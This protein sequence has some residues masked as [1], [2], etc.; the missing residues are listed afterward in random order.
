MNLNRRNAPDLHI[1]SNYKEM[2][3]GYQSSIIKSKSQKETVQFIKQKLDAAKWFIEAINQRYQTLSLTI[4]AIVKFQTEYFLS[5]DEKK[6]KPMIL[7]D[8][9][10]IIKMDISTNSVLPRQGSELWVK[11]KKKN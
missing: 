11:M 8:I 7:K 2:L 3:K 9:A 10:N 4:D 6:L 5:G 1:S